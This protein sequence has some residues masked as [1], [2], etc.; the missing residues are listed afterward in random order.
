MRFRPAALPV[1]AAV[2][3]AAAVTTP[4][5]RA[6]ASASHSGKPTST[7]SVQSNGNGSGRSGTAPTGH[8]HGRPGSGSAQG[9]VQSVDATSVVLTELDGST[10]TISITPATRVFVDGSHARVGEVEPGFVVAVTWVGGKARVLEAFDLS[11]PGVVE[12]GVVRSVSARIV[13]VRRSDG[14]T[15]RIRVGPHTR[16]LLDGSPVSLHA[17]KPGY[18]VV[19][20]AATAK[21]GKPAALLRFLRP[22]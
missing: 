9:I 21:G 7:A 12:M 4:T 20:T 5:G 22:I 17:V 15:V 8:G 6:A 13:V 16:V 18:A 3:L 1:T 11:S 10:V 19:F 14:A 2:L